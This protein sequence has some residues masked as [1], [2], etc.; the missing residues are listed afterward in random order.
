MLWQPSLTY[1]PNLVPDPAPPLADAI[2]KSLFVYGSPAK[3]ITAFFEPSFTVHEALSAPVWV[4][5][6]VLALWPKVVRSTASPTVKKSSIVASNDWANLR[7]SKSAAP[8]P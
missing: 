5:K 8:P 2:E 7:F 1:P 6:K 4:Y 3:L